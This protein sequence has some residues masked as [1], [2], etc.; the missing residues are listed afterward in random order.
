[1]LSTVPSGNKF[2]TN[3]AKNYINVAREFFWKEVQETQQHL[4][5][6]TRL[7]REEFFFLILPLGCF[8]FLPM[9]TCFFNKRLA[10]L[11]LRVTDI[12]TGNLLISL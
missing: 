11:L 9:S 7:G 5:S 1:M 10:K 6:G 8:K 12:K 2:S 4:P 3:G